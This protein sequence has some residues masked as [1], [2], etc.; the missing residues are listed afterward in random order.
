MKQI[1]LVLF[2][3]LTVSAGAKLKN[4]ITGKWSVQK[5]ETTDQSLNSMIQESDFS[6]LIVEFAK[7]GSVLISGTDTKTKY[8][9]DGDKITFSEG[10]AKEISKAEVEANIKSGILTINL[11]AELVKQIMLIVKDQ[12][13]K[14]GGEAFIAKMI[15]NAAKTY[16]IEAVIT[17][18]RK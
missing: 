11:N 3:F 15:E 13:V 6:K 12:Y 9:V 1:I 5:V 17:L 7:S 8:S 18:K 10:L 14:S 16:R 4:E 2:L